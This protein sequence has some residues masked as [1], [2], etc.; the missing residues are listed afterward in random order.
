MS[1]MKCLVR[2]FVAVVICV[3]MHQSEVLAVKR[4]VLPQGL[5]ILTK[6]SDANAIVS[7]VVHLRLGSLYETDAQAGI[8]A[9]MQDTL[10]KGTTNRTSE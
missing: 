5:V 9:L 8:S 10:L 7:V 2:L 1:K 3:S 4:T 6:P